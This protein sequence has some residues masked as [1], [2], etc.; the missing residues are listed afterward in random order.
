MSPADRL[1]V[2]RYEDVSFLQKPIG[3]DEYMAV[4]KRV[5][6]ALTRRYGS[7]A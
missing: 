7:P 5:K 1:M 3:L 2:E 4:G 6:E